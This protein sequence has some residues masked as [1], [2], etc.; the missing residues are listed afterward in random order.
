M[1]EPSPFTTV[2]DLG[3]AGYQQFGVPVSGAMDGFALRAAN[4]LVGNSPN[5]ATLE[6]GLEGP[7]LEAT[8]SCLIA[9]TGTGFDLWIHERP[10]PLWAAIYVRRNREIRLQSRQRGG[11]CYLALAGGIQTPLVLGS[12]STYL[13][14]GFGGLEGRTLQTGDELRSGI[15]SRQPLE[16][17]GRYLPRESRPAYSD[18]LTV[19]VIAGPQLDRFTEAGWQTFL[20]SEYRISASSDRM[21]Y[22]LE[23]PAIEHSA[24]ADIISDGLAAGSVQVPAS[25]QPIVMMSDRPT[26]GGY[27]KI[28]AV[29]SAD[30]PLV[31]QCPPGAGRLRF[32]ETTVEA[33]QAR[34]RKMLNDLRADIVEPEEGTF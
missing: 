5:A 28:A 18:N 7:T 25:G 30:L 26:T 31:A 2:Q 10:M 3:R 20:S 1:L 22:R 12:R 17:A 4:A 34:W 32:R 16:L 23:G 27:P 11:W 15:P 8:E 9:V 19:E 33:A 13:R 29:V 14:G 21:G 6:V 24:G